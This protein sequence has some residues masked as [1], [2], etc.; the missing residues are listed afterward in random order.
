MDSAQLYRFASVWANISRDQLEKAGVI[1]SG[2]SGGSSWS[3]FN[4]DPIMF[5]L[6]LPA[7]RLEALAKLLT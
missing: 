3:R 6:K 2:A 1:D 5:I 4:D 7:R